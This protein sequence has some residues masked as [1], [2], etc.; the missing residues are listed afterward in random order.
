MVNEPGTITLFETATHVLLEPRRRNVSAGYFLFLH[1]SM[2][3]SE[4]VNT[5]Q[6]AKGATSDVPSS[7]MIRLHPPGCASNAVQ[8]SCHRCLLG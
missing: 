6:L 5:P 1:V 4:S 2:T 7:I 8:R 3:V